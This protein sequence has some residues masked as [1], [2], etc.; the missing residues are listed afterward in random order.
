M[1]SMFFFTARQIPPNT[2]GVLFSFFS[3]KFIETDT[4]KT[5]KLHQFLI[6]LFRLYFVVWKLYM[7]CRYW[8]WMVISLFEWLLVCSCFQHLLPWNFVQVSFHILLHYPKYHTMKLLFRT[9]KK[10]TVGSGTL[11]FLST[12]L[13]YFYCNIDL[14]APSTF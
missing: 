4:P 12:K 2:P 6:I 9:Q 11:C 5:T 14:D 3:L 7:L 8:I 13:F 10:S 1:L